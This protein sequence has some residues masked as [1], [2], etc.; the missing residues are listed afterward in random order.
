MATTQQNVFKPAPSQEGNSNENSY[1]QRI[2]PVFRF[3]ST[4]KSAWRHGRRRQQL[5]YA[6]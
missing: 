1:L 4:V 2:M 6:G 5:L 3:F